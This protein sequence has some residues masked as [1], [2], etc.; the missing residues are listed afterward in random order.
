MRLAANGEEIFLAR[1]DADGALQWARRAIAAPYLPTWKLESAPDGGLFL[2]GSLENITT[3][4]PDLGDE[5][6]LEGGNVGFL[7]RLDAAGEVIWARALAQPTGTNGITDV[8][9]HA[10]GGCSVIGAFDRILTLGPG[11][12]AETVLA[13]VGSDFPGRTQ[14]PDFFAA[15]FDAMGE[16]MWARREGGEVWDTGVQVEALEDGATLVAGS[17]TNS[18]TFAQGE[19]VES[20]LTTA[21]NDTTPFFMV[22]E[23]DGSTRWVRQGLAGQIA[24]LSDGSFAVAGTFMGTLTIFPGEPGETTLASAGGWDAYVA[25]LG[26]DP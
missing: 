17:Y 18:V 19:P 8:A 3:F 9:A 20:T 14:V 2:Y 23:R 4:S 21:S 16:L 15:R 5:T 13:A 6:Q 22:I 26:T 12:P 11:E 10:D 7:V 25:R 24:A 1:Y